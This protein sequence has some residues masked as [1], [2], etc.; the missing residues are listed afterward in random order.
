MSL[1]TVYG[2]GGVGASEK[3]QE[4][5]ISNRKAEHVIEIRLIRNREEW[6]QFYHYTQFGHPPQKFPP[7][8][9]CFAKKVQENG[10]RMGDVVTHFATIAPDWEEKSLPESALTHDF[11]RQRMD[12]AFKVGLH[13]EWR[14]VQNT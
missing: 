1:R 10:G 3:P 14:R 6:A 5:G 2:A 12:E 7:W 8:F 9:P 4:S 13:A 11:V